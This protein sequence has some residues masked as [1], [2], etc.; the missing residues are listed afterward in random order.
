MFDGHQDFTTRQP[1]QVASMEDKD[2]FVNWN[3]IL[4]YFNHSYIAKS[5]LS[6][7]FSM[8]SN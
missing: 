3:V 4:I 6:Q 7:F 5:H 2:E 8:S 1:K